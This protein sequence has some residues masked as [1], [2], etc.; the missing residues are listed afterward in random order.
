MVILLFI[1]CLVVFIRK[2]FEIENIN[3][4]FGYLLFLVMEGG[5]F[6][7]RVLMWII[8]VS[9]FNVKNFYVLFYGG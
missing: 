5:D 8:L 1:F 3:F 4:F 6:Y 9:E 7:I 2:F